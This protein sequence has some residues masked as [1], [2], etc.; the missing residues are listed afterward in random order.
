MILEERQ[1]DGSIGFV[2]NEHKKE[3]VMDAVNKEVA[4]LVDGNPLSKC[5]FYKMWQEEFTHVQIP[6]HSRFSK[7][8]DC[9]E[10]RTCLE[11]TKNP[12]EKQVVQKRF[13]QHQ[14]LQRQERRDYWLA[15][16]EA[17][18]FLHNLYA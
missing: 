16:E 13:N 8:E 2:T 14:V 4:G 5:M 6:P 11:A 18:I 7:C 17:I 9:W 10:Y 12:S 3:D 1:E 15:K